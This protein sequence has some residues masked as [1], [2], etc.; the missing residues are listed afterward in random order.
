MSPHSVP[1]KDETLAKVESQTVL[2]RKRASPLI[3]PN[4]LIAIIGGG[5]LFGYLSTKQKRMQDEA[6]L[7]NSRIHASVLSSTQAFCESEVLPHVDPD[8]IEITHSF[9][10]NDNSLPFPATLTIN[11]AK[12]LS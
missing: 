1:T 11:F 6:M 7:V 8:K 10:E 4:I 3:V 5:L 2:D 9:K 12:Y